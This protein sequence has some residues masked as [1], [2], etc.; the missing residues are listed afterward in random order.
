M[1]NEE[2]DYRKMSILKA[3]IDDY[4][5][6]REPVGSRTIA[7]KYGMGLSSAKEHNYRCHGNL[8]DSFHVPGDYMR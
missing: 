5:E 7:K 1:A 8:S 3:V 2:L 4:I 6:T